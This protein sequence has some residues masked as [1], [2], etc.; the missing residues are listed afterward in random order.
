MTLSHNSFQLEK[1]IKALLDK[2]PIAEKNQGYQLDNN[3]HPNV[4]KKPGGAEIG[5][6]IHMIK[7]Q[8]YKDQTH[9][10]RVSFIDKIGIGTQL[11]SP[12]KDSPYSL[13]SLLTLLGIE[14]Y[15]QQYIDFDCVL[16]KIYLDFY[17]IFSRAASSQLALVT[18]DAIIA[19]IHQYITEDNQ[20]ARNDIFHHFI[21]KFEQSIVDVNH[22]AHY[23]IFRSKLIKE[24]KNLG[25][26]FCDYIQKYSK[27]PDTIQS[28]NNRLHLRGLMAIAAVAKVVG[29]P[30]WL[31]AT[32]TN[33]GFTIT[34][35]HKFADAV[36]VDAG[37]SNLNQ[38][39]VTNLDI[40]CDINQTLTIRFSQLSQ[41]QRIEYIET[42]YKL[43]QLTPELIM[44]LIYRKDQWNQLL[45]QE[46]S[47]H[48]VQLLRKTTAEKL[49]IRMMKNITSLKKLLAQ[50]QNPSRSIIKYQ[51]K[52]KLYT[53]LLSRPYITFGMFFSGAFVRQF[54]KNYY[55][56]TRTEQLSTIENNNGSEASLE[57]SVMTEATEQAVSV[58]N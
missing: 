33:T 34:T 52:N 49:S 54:E 58:Y 23:L 5:R 50:V 17:S 12:R 25:E 32:G 9:T 40:Q 26:D 56:I 1:K 31:G 48:P 21:T 46:G 24:Y 41:Q 10:K 13:Y 29:D 4:C 39:E 14:S 28:N 55:P 15:K 45:Q 6:L 51:P 42:L 43:C 3:I 19:M 35:D 8:Q 2:S 37:A 27:P 47:Q 30:D 38:D 20:E 18:K 57:D 11:N 22:P 53:L 7:V 44:T 36:I 16:E